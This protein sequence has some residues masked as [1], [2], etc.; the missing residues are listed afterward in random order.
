[1]NNNDKLRRSNMIL[2]G[3]VILFLLYGVFYRMQSGDSSLYI[4][5]QK[6]DMP[7]ATQQESVEEPAQE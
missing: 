7:F 6:I 1:M 4:F 5:G 2:I 3:I